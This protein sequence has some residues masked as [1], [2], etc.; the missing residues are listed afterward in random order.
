MKKVIENWNET[1]KN[2]I[3]SNTNMV[4]SVINMIKS[5]YNKY[6]ENGDDDLGVTDISNENVKLYE[7][8]GELEYAYEVKYIDIKDNAII[9]ISEDDYGN[10]DNRELCRLT[11]EKIHEIGVAF[12]NNLNKIISN[13]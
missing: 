11:Y 2:W 4:N 9:I 3:E 6:C 13:L 12:S 1:S 7:N 5:V 10:E 8:D